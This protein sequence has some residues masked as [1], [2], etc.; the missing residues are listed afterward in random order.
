MLLFTA[1]V[2]VVCTIYAQYPPPPP[3]PL[4]PSPIYGGGSGGAPMSPDT[5]SS[6]FYYPQPPYGPSHY[7]D[8]SSS[9]DVF[10]P[11][12]LYPN[13]YSS[14][15]EYECDYCPRVTL[16]CRNSL[17]CSRPK[18]KYLTGLCKAVVSCES[19]DESMRL[20]TNK[21]DVLAEG[22]GVSKLI[23]CKRGRWTAKNVLGT[24]STFRGL[25]CLTTEPNEE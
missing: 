23:T 16:S 19:F 15:R 13:S 1:L 7:P 17:G 24:R 10:Y 4:P 14:S 22:E 9:Y 3:F 20:T 18:I 11:H 12:D 21:G 25:R 6:S 8:Y 2:A 5:S